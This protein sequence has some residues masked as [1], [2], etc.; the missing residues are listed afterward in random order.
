MDVIFSIRSVE[1][2]SKN[3]HGDYGSYYNIQFFV[4]S[5]RPI[6]NKVVAS[7]SSPFV[8]RRLILQSMAGA[9]LFW[10]SLYIFVPT[11]PVYAQSKDSSLA[12]VGL[13]LAQYGLWQ[14][15]LRFPLG[16]AADW[17]GRRK[18]FILA[19]F[20]LAALGA[21]I[22]GSATGIAGIAIGRAVTGLAVSSWVV[23][24]VVY[25]GLFPPA[26]ATRA[27]ATLTLV[28]SL[29]Q[30]AASLA[31][32]PLTALGGYAAGFIVSMAAAGAGLL[33]WL[34]GVETRLP[35]LRPSLASTRRLVL[36]KDVLGPAL[37]NAVQLYAVFA[38]IFGFTPILA[39]RFGATTFQIGLLTTTNIAVNVAGNLLASL[40]VRRT[41]EVPLVYA[42]FI[43]LAAGIAATAAAPGLAWLFFAQ[44]LMGLGGGIGY[45]L[46]LGLSIAQVKEGERNT[47]MGLHQA[48]YGIGMFAGPWLSGLLAVPLGI[49]SMFAV[50]AGVVLGIGILGTWILNRK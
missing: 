33:V 38:A 12:L 17:L 46:L 44:V 37:L 31:S 21:W 7:I 35:P 2:A 1:N 32:G 27:A 28:N 42:S 45:P 50:T 8:R 11:L 18:P 9:F 26:E 29:A 14:A 13:A 30:G 3:N 23:M 39:A 36:R 24:V 41:G 10:M 20:I 15:L 47:A 22:M 4:G 43:L 34:P 48:V 6:Y 5:R 16:L 49:Q 40:L 19:G 25:S